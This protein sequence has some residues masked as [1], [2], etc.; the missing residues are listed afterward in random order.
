MEAYKNQALSVEERV[1]DLLS[2]MT[3]KEKVAQTLSLGKLPDLFEENLMNYNDEVE[4]QFEDDIFKHGAGAIQMAFKTDSIETRIKKLN[5]MQNYFLNK[6]RLGIPVMAQEECLHGHLA[7][8]ATCFPVPIALASTWDQELV[9]RVFTAIGKETSARGGHEAHTPV[10]DLARDPRWGRTEETYGEDTYLVTRMGVAAV[11]GLQEHVIAAPKHFAG[12]AQS[13]GGRNFAPSN[14][15]PRVLKD[16]I[17]PPFKAVVEEAG[18]LGMMPSHNEIDGVPCHSSKYLLTELLREEWGFEGIVVSDYSDSSRLDVL[19]HVVNNQKEAAIKALKAGLDMDLPSGYCY[20]H[21]IEAVTEQPELEAVLDIAVARI[22]RLKFHLGLFE[23][24]YVDP[25]HAK[26]IINCPDHVKIAKEAADKAIT[27]LK[28]EGNL[29]PLNTQNIQTLAVIGPNA[30]PICTGTY[31]TIPNKGISILESIKQKYEGE[32]D[33]R[34]AQGCKITFETD[35]S[36]ESELDKRVHNP[37]LCTMAE[38][39]ELI[40]EAVRI[41]KESDIAVLCVGGNTLTSR[42]AIFIGDDR[43]DRTDLNLAG[44]Q[45]E[46]V[47]RIVETGTPIVVILTNGTPLSINYIAE[48]VPAILEG[49]YLGEETGNAIADVLFGK[50]NPSGKLPITFPRSVGQLPVYYSQKP[51]GLF[52]KYLFDQ[53]DGPL[54]AFGTGLSYTTFQYDNLTISEKNISISSSTSV[55]VDVTNIGELSGDEIVQL[56]VSDVVS[57][58]T[59]PIKELKGFKRVTL[60]PGETKSVSFTVEPS[61]LSFTNED[62]E[63]VVEPGEFKIMVGSSSVEYQSVVLQVVES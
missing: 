35:I 59:R 39:K 29:L 45:N 60:H 21:L 32:I 50:V 34:F 51:T 48:H 26:Q 40:E 44:D 56:Y 4:L 15:P 8:G 9:E 52:K 3:L 55:T 62:F 16:Q 28:N 58:V 5:A 41:A 42:E 43:G 20:I 10:L 53:K 46:L 22:L 14:I 19:F 36:G 31:S 54:F 23:R 2:R 63:T 25:E 1:Q 47:R 27:L 11:K 57:S 17:L 7:K 6:T 33:I 37:K 24:P 49:W 38:N 30:D 12:Y 61:M 18:A 13:D